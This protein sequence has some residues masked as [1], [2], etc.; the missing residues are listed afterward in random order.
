MKR[1]LKYVQRFMHLTF[2][3]RADYHNIIKWYVDESYTTHKEYNGN[4]GGIMIKVKVNVVIIPKKKS[5]TKEA[6]P[7]PISLA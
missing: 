7:I 1:L 5:L 2:I 3:L 4:T 6:P